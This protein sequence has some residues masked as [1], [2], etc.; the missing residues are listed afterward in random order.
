MGY[1][2]LMDHT[3]LVLDLADAKAKLDQ[4]H[5][6]KAVLREALT[7]LANEAAATIG[8]CEQELRQMAGNTNVNVLAL[9]TREARQ[10]L[11]DPAPRA[12]ALLAVVEAVEIIAGRRQCAD[13]LMSNQ[14]VAEAALARWEGRDA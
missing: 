3:A 10:A 1:E 8:A 12:Q 6:E 9:R 5:T 13:N 2:E 4:V 11:A 7:K 14:D